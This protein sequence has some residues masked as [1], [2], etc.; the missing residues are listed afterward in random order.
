MLAGL[1]PLLLSHLYLLHQQVLLALPSIHPESKCFSPPPLLPLGS[2]PT[3]SPTWITYY[4]NSLLICSSPSAFVFLE[5]ILSSSQRDPFKANQCKSLLL[6]QAIIESHLT[7]SNV[8]KALM[9]WLPLPPGLICLCFWFCSLHSSTLPSSLFHQQ[10]N[11]PP[12]SWSLYLKFPSP[13]YAQSSLSQ[14]FMA[15]TLTS[16][17][18][19]RVPFSVRA[20]LDPLVK[21]HYFP[22]S[23]ISPAWFYLSLHH[24]S[25]DSTYLLTLECKPLRARI[26][27]V[28]F[29][30]LSPASLGYNAQ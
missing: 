23:L 20:F 11:H 19:F 13:R 2:K 5:T 17:R 29:T 9:F 4:C 24:L 7:H 6:A 26:L 16:L 3:S 30:A 28:S 14:I 15:H 18:S 21:W 12:I 22:P 27:P 10:T 25:A 8:L 1:T